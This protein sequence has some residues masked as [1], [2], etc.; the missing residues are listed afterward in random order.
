[1]KKTVTVL[2]LFFVVTTVLCF[3]AIAADKQQFCNRYADTAVRQYNLGKQHNLPGIVPP[4]W[5]ND[6]N[7]HFNWCMTVLKNFADS[8][9][10][11]RQ[12][13][14]DKNILKEE[15]GNQVFTG[16]IIGTVTEL[17]DMSNLIEMS[18]KI[19]A[20]Y[21]DES[22][23]QNKQNISMGCGFK[24]PSWSTDY[25]AHKNWCM[26]GSNFVNA[27]KNLTKRDKQLKA[28]TFLAKNLW[29]P[30]MVLG[31]QHQLGAESIGVKGNVGS[32]DKF[33]PSTDYFLQGGITFK[34]NRVVDHKNMLK[35]RFEW[36][37][38]TPNILNL[39]YNKDNLKMLPPGIV[40]GLTGPGDKGLDS[41]FIGT[42]GGAFKKECGGDDGAFG[43]SGL[44]WYERKGKNLIDL[45]QLEKLPRGTIVGLKH[46]KNQASKKLIWGNSVF[47][48]VNP[49]INP[50]LGFERRVGGDDGAPAGVG[51]FWYEKIT[52]E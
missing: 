8:E 47:D 17:P 9:Q 23:R 46:S 34:T 40:V 26:H 44:C 15:S 24:P 50:P 10:G 11:K 1:M 16:T 39:N 49:N 13:Y 51:Y 14:L 41:E 7:G 21:A 52:G 45:C 6:R 43:G 20:H 36:L 35:H 4:A 19:C 18:E 30:Q 38:F 33:F 27:D 22:V 28:C 37:W 2:V 12:A 31:L 5:S 32:D 48:P 42:L 29:V 25:N 3:Q